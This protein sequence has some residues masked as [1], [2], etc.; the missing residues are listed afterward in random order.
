MTGAKRAHD[1]G[2][3]RLVYRLARMRVV[4]NRDAFV[5]SLCAGRRVLHLGCADTELLDARLAEG[6]LLHARLTKVAAECAGVDIDGAGLERLQRAG[7]SDLH[8]G[9]AEALTTI[10]SI[11]GREF[12]IIVVGEVIE[13]LGN[14]GA[15]LDQCA[16]LLREGGRC[17]VTTPNALS[18]AS[19][20]A[21]FL[22]RELVHSSHVM[23]WTPVTLPRL[24]SRSGLALV[25]L[26]GYRG[27]GHV[28][29]HGRSWS[30]RA[31]R[32]FAWVLDRAV[33]RIVVALWPWMCDGLIAV[34]DLG[35]SK[36]AD[37]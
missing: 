25:E 23:I 13:H 15:M 28:G 6:R 20:G 8:Q 33:D 21:A 32:A 5:E 17:V 7:F 19:F 29:R 1:A 31:L 2:G 4:P 16:L 22:G 9:S 27:S 12:D 14:P 36:P 34:F 37:A 30:R 11:H 18:W 35:E 24:G 3:C 26:L 10:E